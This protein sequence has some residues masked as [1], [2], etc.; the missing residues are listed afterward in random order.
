MMGQELTL[1]L[2]ED[3]LVD[4][5]LEGTVEEGVEHGVGL[6]LDVVV[7]L[8]VLLEALSAVG[9]MLALVLSHIEA[10]SRWPHAPNAGHETREGHVGVDACSPRSITILELQIEKTRQ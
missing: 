5:G 7:G 1:G 10:E 2:D 3:T 8:H 6:G 4:T 9:S